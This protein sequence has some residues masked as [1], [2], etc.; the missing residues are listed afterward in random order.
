MKI[1]KKCLR[2]ASV[3]VSRNGELANQ[4]KCFKEKKENRDCQLS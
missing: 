1:D 4:F 3:I 2:M